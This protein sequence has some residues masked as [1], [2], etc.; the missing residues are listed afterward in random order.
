ILF[1]LAPA[2]QATSLTLGVRATS[3]G[4]SR[5]SRVLIAS[6]VALS[7]VLLVGTGLFLRNLWNLRNV[8]TGYAWEGL[9][10]ARIDPAVL[11]YQ[12]PQLTDLY[13]RL[14]ERVTAIP[15]VRSASLSLEAPISGSSW[16]SNVTV[17]GSTARQGEN[18]DVHRMIVTPDYFGTVGLPLIEGRGFTERDTANSAPVAVVNET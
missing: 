8:D 17:A 6:Q 1:G 14:L 15:G 2:V 11:E 18:L 5:A 4:R 13:R 16:T 10:T 7:T 9:L 12:K 3:R